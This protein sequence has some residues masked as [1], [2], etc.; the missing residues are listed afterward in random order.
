MACPAGK[1]G[2]AWGPRLA[3]KQPV[4]R[5]AATLDFLHPMRATASPV[6]RR[7]RNDD[8]HDT[9]QQVGK[10]CA[11]TPVVRCGHCV[12]GW[13]PCAGSSRRPPPDAREARGRLSVTA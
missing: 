2:C 12:C 6:E 13:N 9:Q 10:S 3:G 4:C 1:A 11:L 8:E 5:G 7:R